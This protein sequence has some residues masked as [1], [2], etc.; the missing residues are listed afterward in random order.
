MLF[1]RSASVGKCVFLPKFFSHL[2]AVLQADQSRFEKFFGVKFDIKK[3]ETVRP[4]KTMHV[5]C[6]CEKKCLIHK[7]LKFN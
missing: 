5:A 4:G 3:D 1:V 6:S 2:H 7:V